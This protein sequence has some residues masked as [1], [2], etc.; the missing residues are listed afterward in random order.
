[1]SGKLAFNLLP[2][3]LSKIKALGG[4]HMLEVRVL[5]QSHPAFY[6]I[7]NDPLDYVK[8]KAV[9][10]IVGLCT[11]TVSIWLYGYFIW[12]LIPYHLGLQSNI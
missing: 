9:Q 11:V 12:V 5:L 7:E 2:I 6:L 3:F 10:A 8:V 1:M 4:L